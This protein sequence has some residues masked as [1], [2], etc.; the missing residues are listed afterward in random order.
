M[1]FEKF[2]NDQKDY[3]SF[4]TD[5]AKRKEYEIGVDWK[6]DMLTRAL[7]EDIKFKSILEVGC[8]FG[9]VLDKFTK[10]IKIKDATGLDIATENIKFAKEMF[11]E[12]AFYSGTIENTFLDK[13]GLPLKQFDLV[14]LSDIVEHVPD[15]LGFMKNVSKL[16][17][18]VLLNLPL[19]KSFSNRNRNYG[20]HDRSGHLKAY[21]PRDARSLI[22]RA[23]FKIVKS[24]YVNSLESKEL[25]KQYKDAQRARLAKKSMLKRVFWFVIYNSLETLYTISPRFLYK[26]NGLNLFC[27]L[28]TK[29]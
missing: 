28:E 5:E 25:F 7:P 22:D 3:L 24:I 23:G 15:E 18:Y 17:R 13:Q 2:Y 6:I 26:M 8:A 9:V 27:L 14:L 29:K 19:E 12:L 20:I 11:P 4:R 10:K 21:D 16:S 1:D